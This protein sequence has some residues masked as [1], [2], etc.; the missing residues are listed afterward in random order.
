MKKF[1][2]FVALLM[3]EAFSQAGPI[4]LSFLQDQDAIKDTIQVLKDNGC[5]ESNAVVFDKLVNHYFIEPF[6]FDFAKFP[7]SVSGFYNFSTTQALVSA[8]PHR[9]PDTL[10][11]YGINCID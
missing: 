2:M 11:S 7:K 9:L 4:R 3:L 1:V 10:H 8:L 6:N 5:V